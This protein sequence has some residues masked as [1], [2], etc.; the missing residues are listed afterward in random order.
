MLSL[1]EESAYRLGDR[2]LTKL[3]SH[4][5]IATVDARM[6]TQM[7]PAQRLQCGVVRN[8][9]KGQTAMGEADAV[10]KESDLSGRR[11]AQFT[12]V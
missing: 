3:A 5:C 4:D 2:I 1:L 9:N 12:T 10:R 6:S 7:L 11:Y 8:L